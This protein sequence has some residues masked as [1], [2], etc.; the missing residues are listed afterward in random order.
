M[1]A[2]HA[3]DVGI[4]HVAVCEP[5]PEMMSADA[6]GI[7]VGVEL[8]VAHPAEVSVHACEPAPFV[9]AA[10]KYRD[11]AFGLVTRQP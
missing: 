5:V 7:C 9:P 2:F 6:P 8:V 1:A 3:T 10:A 11:P 4:V